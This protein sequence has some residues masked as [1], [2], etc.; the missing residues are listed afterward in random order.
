MPD[1]LPISSTLGERLERLRVRSGI[2]LNEVARRAKIGPGQVWEILH[3][4]NANPKIQTIERMV[5]AMGATLGELFADDLGVASKPPR[6][7]SAE[8]D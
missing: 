1:H 6:E 8:G 5:K 3:G 2:S 4:K 7:K